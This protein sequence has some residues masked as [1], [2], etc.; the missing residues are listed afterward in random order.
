MQLEKIEVQCYSGRTYAERPISFLWQDKQYEVEEIEQ[1][2][3]EPGE[4][5]FNIR[6]KNKQSFHLWYGEKKDQWHLILHSLS[7]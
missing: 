2:W 7:A 5:H 6:T 3:L 4:K 1:E